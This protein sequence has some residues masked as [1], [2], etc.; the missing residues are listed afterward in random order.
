MKKITILFPVCLILLFVFG[1]TASKKAD[2]PV[3]PESSEVRSIRIEKGGESTVHTDEEYIYEF[4]ALLAGLEAANKESIQDHPYVNEYIT[5]YLNSSGEADTTLFFYEENGTK[6]LEQPY[7]GIYLS[8]PALENLITLSNSQD[9]DSGEKQ[10][11][12]ML[13]MDELISSLSYEEPVISFTIPRGNNDWSIYINGRIEEGQG[14]M[15]VHYLE[16]ESEYKSWI[17]GKTYSFTLLEGIHTELTMSIALGEERETVNLR[18]LI[19]EDSLNAFPL[20]F[21]REVD[22][23]LYPYGIR[24]FYQSNELSSPDLLQQTP[25]SFYDSSEFI[26][27]ELWFSRYPSVKTGNRIYI[28]EEDSFPDVQLQISGSSDIINLSLTRPNRLSEEEWEEVSLLKADYSADIDELTL[29]LQLNPIE[30]D[31]KKLLLVGQMPLSSPNLVEWKI[32]EFRAEEYFQFQL[33]EAVV[34]ADGWLYGSGET[35]PIRISLETGEVEVLEELENTVKSLVADEGSMDSLPSTRYIVPMGRLEEMV[36]W[37]WTVVAP[38]SPETV[39]CLFNHQE[40]MGA[41]HLQNDGVWNLFNREGSVV[42]GEMSKVYQ[43]EIY[44]PQ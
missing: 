28:H 20:L 10:V 8:V 18:E 36:I 22:G 44:F 30:A 37:S 21:Y 26:S 6:Y 25:V 31:E 42:R 23:E 14:G 2:P 27:D 41:I 7:Q 13:A 33:A 4:V 11:L 43:N 19:T 15:S 38:N 35:S 1:C 32:F 17:G 29:V 9:T 24:W 5:I 12:R 34:I 40:S 16:E 39:Y 3:L